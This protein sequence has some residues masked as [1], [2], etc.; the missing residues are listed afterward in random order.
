MELKSE[1][2]YA[3]LLSDDFR[4][5]FSAAS[6]PDLLVH[7]GDNWRKTDEVA[8]ITNLFHGFKNEFGETLAGASSINMTLYGVQYL[9]SDPDHPDSTGQYRKVVVTTMNMVIEVPSTPDPTVY[10][11]NSRHEFFLVRGD[12]AVLAPGASADTTRWYV[13]KWDDMASPLAVKGPVI[14][15]SNAITLGSIRARYAAPPPAFE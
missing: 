13:R 1:T 15:P 2:Q 14:N 7:Y 11:V 12:A 9:S 5:H 6:D 4:Y 10:Q 8:A 3:L